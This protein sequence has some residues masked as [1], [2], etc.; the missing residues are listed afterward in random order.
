MK[1][2]RC[3]ENFQWML[4]ML[5]LEMHLDF[6]KFFKDIL[7]IGSL[8]P[9]FERTYIIYTLNHGKP[10]WNRWVL[11]LTTAI[12]TKFYP[13][14]LTSKTG[15]KEVW[16]YPKPNNQPH[17]WR[18]R[19][20]SNKN[21]ETPRK[22]QRMLRMLL[23]FPRLSFPVSFLSRNW[24]TLQEYTNWKWILTLWNFSTQPLLFQLSM[25]IYLKGDSLPIPTT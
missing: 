23:S 17:S 9:K 11:E 15:L 10:K 24:N 13:W 2:K 19:A 3:Q 4:R 14:Q 12:Q 5:K 16:K 20:P 1:T 25:V 18:F 7:N 22:F 8:P 6:V 21:Q